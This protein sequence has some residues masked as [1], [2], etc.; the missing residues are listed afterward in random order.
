MGE[1]CVFVLDVLLVEEGKLFGEEKLSR[2]GSE[3]AFYAW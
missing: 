3:L 1:V 2:R